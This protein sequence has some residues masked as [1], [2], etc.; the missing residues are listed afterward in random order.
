M[1]G[2][3][4]GNKVG[5]QFQSGQ[6]GNPHGATRGLR[7]V[8]AA[9]KV[10]TEEMLR[11]LVEIARNTKTTAAARAHAATYVL[12]R[13]WGRPQASVTVTKE[14][15][16]RDLTDDALIDELIAVVNANGTGEGEG[17]TGDPF[18]AQGD[19]EKLN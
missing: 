16:Y 9:A 3:E 14:G 4:K 6:S 13:A 1:A 15:S 12:D 11:I 19:P 7:E 17:L 18:T 5:K 8:A 2:F 10:H